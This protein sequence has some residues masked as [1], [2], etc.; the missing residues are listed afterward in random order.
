MNIM[1]LLMRLFSRQATNWA[2][3]KGT[4]GIA[5][6]GG[7][8]SASGKMTPAAKKQAQDMRQT[9]KRARQAARIT[10]RLGR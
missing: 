9:V 2:M 8:G 5:G 7:G 6:R 1:N 4:D 10:R 3:R